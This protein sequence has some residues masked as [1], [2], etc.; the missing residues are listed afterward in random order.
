MRIGFDTRWLEGPA[1]AAGIA[2]YIRSLLAELARIDR[3]NEYSLWGENI[4]TGSPS[5]RH[6]RFTGLYRR[7]WQLAWKTLRWPSIRWV[8]PAV[9]LWHFTNFVAPPTDKP[10]VLTVYD[11]TFVEHPEFV[12]PK[13]LAYLRRFVPESL[14]RAAQVITISDAMRNGII[15]QFGLSE[16][17]VTRIYP[18][19]DQRFLRRVQADE[20]IGVKQR[21]GIGGDYLITVGTLEPRKNL[22]GLLQAFAQMSAGMSEYLVVVGGQGWL[23]EETRALLQKLGLG[24]RVIL[25][26]YVP[27]A[28][29]AVLYH[30]AKLFIFP[31]HYEGFGIPLL[32]AM[33]AGLPVACSNTSSLPEIAGAAAVYFDPNDPES[34]K[35]A[36]RRILTDAPLRDALRR[37]GSE[38]IQ[39][40]S[41]ERTAKETLTIYEEVAGRC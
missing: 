23:F 15:D 40:F 1:P 5:V 24:S 39:H 38:R 41:W 33:A 32:E 21:Y 9:D 27:Q 13:N 30:G 25:T 20:I 18:A 11:L 16:S 34:M 17:K 19:F 37:A 3:Q 10:F 2:T 31:S 22:R 8:A 36:I 14:A 28:D 12:E 35:I 4:P 7:A 6:A 29:L 26:G